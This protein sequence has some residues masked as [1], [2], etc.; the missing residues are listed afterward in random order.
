MNIN[1]NNPL[2]RTVLSNVQHYDH[3]KYWKMRKEVTNPQ[4]KLP[5]LIRLFY[6][7][8]IKRMDAFNNASMGTDLGKGAQFLDPPILWHGLN[9]IIISHYAKIGRNCQIHQ[10]VTIAE[11]NRESA[12]IGDNCF[13][14]AGAVIIGG[15]TIGN[16]VK[17][18]ANSVVTKDIP[19]NCTVVGAPARIVNKNNNNSML[20]E[21]LVQAAATTE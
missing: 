11:D 19:D 21:A 8:R 13:I 6:L 18:G 4:S 20:N 7:Y 14:G 9:G 15:V 3:K 10:R 1:I 12:I 17:I 5:K 16:N 2:I